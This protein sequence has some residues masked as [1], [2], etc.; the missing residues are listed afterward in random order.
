VAVNEAVER[1]HNEGIL[2][3]ASLMMS[4]AAVADAV[5]RAGRT[6]GLGV[7]LHLVLVDGRPV[8]PPDRVPDLVAADGRFRDNMVAAGFAFL[9]PRVRR[10]LAAEIEAQFAAFAATG[11]TLDHVNAHKH[12]HLHPVIAS[13]IIRIGGRFGARAV[14][15]PIEP[16][17]VLRG[18]EAHLP[19]GNRLADFWARRVARRL[20]RAG[21]TVPGA[22]FGLGWSGAMTGHRLR[23]V[24]ARLPDGLSEI[25]LHP[26]IGPY[27]GGGAGYDHAGEFVGLVD[28]A[29][30]SAATAAGVRLGS[31]RA[32]LEEG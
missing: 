23:G 15:A 4:G 1:A 10:Q 17:H 7:G 3:A 11:L 21:F 12:F 6:P 25:Y 9:R 32:L 28:P 27:G 18:I 29:S 14:R 26:A 20:E 22:V 19:P 24:I 16:R 5:E 30:R 8:L 13:E 31:F 2:S